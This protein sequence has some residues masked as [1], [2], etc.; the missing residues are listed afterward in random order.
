MGTAA[1][2]AIGLT[3]CI[4]DKY[5][6]SDIDT[7]VRIN[8]ND[9][10]LPVKMDPVEL[11]NVINADSSDDQTSTS[12]FRYNAQTGDYYI[13]TDGEFNAE[14]VNIDG[15]HVDA[16]DP[17]TRLL[18]I[19]VVPGSEK[20]ADMPDATLTDLLYDFTYEF[21]EVDDYIQD[22][23]LVTTNFAIN[24][25][26]K[27]SSPEVS[28]T[29]M[30]FHFPA[31]LVGTPVADGGRHTA[32]YDIEDGTLTIYGTYSEMNLVF[33]VDQI[34]LH[35]AGGSFDRDNTTFTFKN[36]IGVTDATVNS[37]I[38]SQRETIS[39]DY[40]LSSLEVTAIT[41]IIH[42]NVDVDDSSV[43]L[44]DLPK[45]LRQEGTDI[46]LLDPQILL[47]VNNPLARYGAF[48]E[49]GLA[50]Y[51]VREGHKSER[52][53]AELADVK[54]GYDNQDN[55]PLSEQTLLLAPNK[56]DKFEYTDFVPFEGLGSVVA[57]NGLP[58]ELSIHLL[59][60][61]VPENTSVTDFPIGT[62]IA[63]KIKG[64]YT[65][66]APL[67]LAEGST[68]AYT[69]ED[70]GWDIENADDLHVDL[71]EIAT[72]VTSEMPLDVKLI[73]I[74]LDKDGNEIIDPDKITPAIIKANTSSHVVLKVQGDIVGIDGVRYTATVIADGSKETLNR[75][76][77]LKLDN[78]RGKINGYYQSKL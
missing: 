67:A 39:I 21:H 12:E 10:V 72:D 29:D 4:D 64:S 31:G 14:D 60:P 36:E 57:G 32:E 18:T 77:K 51:Q 34:Y 19:P 43:S 22:I 35:Q 33:N 25:T 55:K 76:M 20:L 63:E 70:R 9:L 66:Y 65:F 27:T 62:P 1:T 74:P 47:T 38:A 46:T 68:I 24:M 2:L 78:L 30:Q 44:S 50:I 41:G 5:D 71:L 7:T 54:I 6:L 75:T 59:N 45:E 53:S 11:Q 26:V 58:D 16:L 73:A 40:D 23:T 48:A 15:I 13:M 69:D 42:Y 17:E 37:A 28:L 49:T 8:V 61:R 56:S 3:G 52:P